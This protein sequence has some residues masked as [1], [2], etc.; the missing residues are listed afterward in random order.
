MGAGGVYLLQVDLNEEGG[1]LVWGR[2]SDDFAGG[3]GDEAL[4]PELDAVSTGGGFETGAVDGG[5]IATIG[6]GMGALCGLP[7]RVLLGS[8]GGFLGGVPAYGG[9]VK[10]DLSPLEC[11]E[12]CGFGKPLIPTDE[13]A[14]AAV[15]GGERAEAEVA[16]GEVE[17]FVVE[18]VVGDVH[19]AVDAEEIAVGVDD[20][21]G[22]MVETRG[23]LFEQG[24]DDDDAMF[25][26]DV[27][28]GAGGGAGDGFGESEVGILF[29]LAEVLGAEELLG[30][31]DLGALACGALGGG[32]GFA[33]VNGGLGIATVLEEGEGD[34]GGLGHGGGTG[35][36]WGGEDGMAD[37]LEGV[38]GGGLAEQFTNEAAERFVGWAVTGLVDVVF[39]LEEEF[40]GVGIAIVDAAG[41][42][43]VEDAV[44]AVIDAT[45]ELAKVGELE[46]HDAVAGL[47]GGGAFKD[48]V[49]EEE[50]AEDDA[51]GEEVGAFIGDLEVGL[52][53]AHIIG[54]AGDDFPFLV[55]EEAAGFGDAEVGKFHIAFEGDHDVFETDIAVDDAEQAA[56]AVGFGVGVCEPASDPADDEDGEFEGQD[57]A[58]FAE[59]FGELFQIHAA[60]VFHHDEVEIL[61]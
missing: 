33:E 16:G 38:G 29:R 8:K 2:L 43:A 26:G 21:R 5:H 53:G 39:E 4:A 57:A 15:A 10:E 58:L 13:H 23:A 12:A 44:Q 3:A 25:A 46:G 42:R 41:E 31:D 50:V 19:L 56:V 47:V 30:A 36:G 17:L 1:L 49:A 22:V 52:F 48:V 7:G 54:L 35:S 20:G 11:G 6:D 45:V 59:V 27:L 28:E 37:G 9:R 60:D 18:G 14:E 34:R 51:G 61:V 40:G 55:L 24:N 32:E